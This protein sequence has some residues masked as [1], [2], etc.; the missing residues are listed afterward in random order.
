[1]F[2]SVS[3][4]IKVSQTFFVVWPG[5]YDYTVSKRLLSCV[6]KVVV[7]RVKG[8]IY[9]VK[10]LLLTY[11]FILISQTTNHLTRKEENPLYW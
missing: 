2:K 7:R 6:E 11:L 9:P 1:M 3:E 8:Y 4:P 10:Y 5:L